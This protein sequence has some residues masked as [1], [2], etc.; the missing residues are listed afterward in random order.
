MSDL[1][2]VY[3]TRHWRRGL[4]RWLAR[5]RRGLA[6][7]LR[8]GARHTSRDYERFMRSPAWAEQRRRVLRRDGYR[9]RDCFT[10]KATE[11]HHTYYLAPLAATPDEAIRSLCEPCHLRAHR[12]RR[13]A[14]TS[15]R[16]W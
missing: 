12:A 3:A 13:Y 14:P 15:R 2:V 9:C 1:W 10:A 5:T 4:A 6:R 16:P 8:W 7:R 11:A